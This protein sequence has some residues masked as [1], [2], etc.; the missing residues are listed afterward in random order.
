MSCAGYVIVAGYRLPVTINEQTVPRV[1]GR[2]IIA[3]ARQSTAQTTLV[4]GRLSQFV[5]VRG[6]VALPLNALISYVLL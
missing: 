2:N 3:L 1:D 4:M 6:L 5:Y